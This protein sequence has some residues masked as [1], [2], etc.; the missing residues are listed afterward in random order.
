MG[1]DK[2]P[3]QIPRDVGVLAT[4]HWVVGE[5]PAW[6]AHI[7]FAFWVVSATEPRVIV[8]LGCHYGNSYFAFAQSVAACGLPTSM[9][10]IDTWEGDEHSGLYGYEVFDAVHDYNDKTYATFSQLVRSTFDE[11]GDHFEDG[12]VDLLHI[13]GHHTYE[14]VRHDFESWL[15]KMS[16]RGV[17]L[18]HDIAVRE[19]GFGVHRLW[20]ELADQHESF[21]F[22]H[23]HGLGVLAVGSEVPEGLRS[24][25]ALERDRRRKRP[26]TDCSRRW[27]GDCMS[28]PL[29]MFRLPP[30]AMLP[31][32]KWPPLTPNR[33]WRSTQLAPSTPRASTRFG[34]NRPRSWL[35]PARSTS[36]SWKRFA[37]STTMN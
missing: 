16:D 31:R 11:A 6:L 17:V 37:P 15:P 4:P 12:T 5:T 10:A 30:L 23:S 19:R 18:F 1:Q 7:P 34:Q 9:F 3:V 24:L 29:W 20:D 22:D 35:L 27:A 36:R 2:F 25:F 21:A 32:S 8:E 26:S 33:L 13:D 14:A 28:R